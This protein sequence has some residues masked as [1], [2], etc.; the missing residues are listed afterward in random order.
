MNLLFMVCF[1]TSSGPLKHASGVLIKNQQISAM[2]YN[3]H[4]LNNRSYN[5]AFILIRYTYM[6]LSTCAQKAHKQTRKD[7]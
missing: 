1:F 5:G 6:L 4:I 3:C 2:S 7:N